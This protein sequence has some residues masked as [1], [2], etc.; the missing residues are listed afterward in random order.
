MTEKPN[1]HY[2]DCPECGVG[3]IQKADFSGSELSPALV[4]LAMICRCGAGGGAL[5]RSAGPWSP[6]E[7]LR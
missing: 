6:K 1:Y 7:G 2:F 4:I 5:E 3:S